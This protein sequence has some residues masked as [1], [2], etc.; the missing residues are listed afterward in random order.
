MT[1]QPGSVFSA[2]TTTAVPQQNA[3]DVVNSSHN[4]VDPAYFYTSGACMLVIGVMG[5]VGNFLMLCVM[6]RPH[7]KNKSYAHFLSALAVS[8]SI[9]ILFLFFQ[10]I[11]S[12][13]KVNAGQHLTSAFHNAGCQVF[14]FVEHIF[15]FNSA[16]LIGFTCL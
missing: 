15:I 7:L 13:V 8:D 16:W 1:S 9:N 14:D 11:N 12:L 3:S 10:Y 2:P 6:K 4:E 5:I